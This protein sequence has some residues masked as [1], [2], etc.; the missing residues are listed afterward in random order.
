MESSLFQNVTFRADASCLKT[1]PGKT[2]DEKE[3]L[4]FRTVRTG[5]RRAHAAADCGFTYPDCPVLLQLPTRPGE[6]YP[7]KTAGPSAGLNW[8][9]AMT[10]KISRREFHRIAAA[11][12]VMAPIAGLAQEKTEKPAVQAATPA[13]GE[14]VQEVVAKQ[15]SEMKALRSHTLPYGL[16]PAFTFQA[17]PRPR[18]APSVT[19]T[20]PKG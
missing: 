18:R 14:K 8:E 3:V 16:E 6:R 17:R 10:K 7:A 12:A 15:E 1:C 4:F 9:A 5:R 13:T 11:G 20:P 19:L 2:P